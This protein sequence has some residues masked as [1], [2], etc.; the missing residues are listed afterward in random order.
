MIVDGGS[1]ALGTKSELCRHAG[2]LQ[3]NE[4]I[5]IN[6]INIYDEAHGDFLKPRER[7]SRI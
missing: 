2:M 6:C 5:K 7:V 3:L 4:Y 1:I